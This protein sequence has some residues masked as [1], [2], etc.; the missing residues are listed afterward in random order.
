MVVRSGKSAAHVEIVLK[1]FRDALVQRYEAALVELGLADVQNATWQHIAKPEMERL[2][3]AQAGRGDE[4]EQRHVKLSP[5]RVR[6]LPAQLSDGFEDPGQLIPAV[7]IGN[8]P[9]FRD[10][11]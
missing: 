4:S 11:E 7:D 8:R 6:L 9:Q 10:G 2:R 1:S 5:Q 3:H